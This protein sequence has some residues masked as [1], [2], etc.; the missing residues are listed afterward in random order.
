MYVNIFSNFWKSES[1]AKRIKTNEVIDNIIVIIQRI[2]IVLLT[3]V[4]QFFEDVLIAQTMLMINEAIGKA[5]NANRIQKNIL[6]IIPF[7]ESSSY[8]E[9]SIWENLN[10]L[11][12]FN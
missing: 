2:K 9:K 10:V 4:D 12:K 5:H 7:K 6:P 1:A 11:K 3:I 8:L